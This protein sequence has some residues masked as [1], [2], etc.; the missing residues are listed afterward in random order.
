MVLGGGKLVCT[1]LLRE[2][3]VVFYDWRGSFFSNF[4]F[5]KTSVNFSKSGSY[6]ETVLMHDRDGMCSFGFG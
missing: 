5:K 6:E 3:W 4:T 2:R 1:L